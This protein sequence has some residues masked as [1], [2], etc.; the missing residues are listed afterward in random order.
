MKKDNRFIMTRLQLIKRLTG[1]PVIFTTTITV[2]L[3]YLMPRTTDLEFVNTLPFFAFLIL[4]VIL[5]FSFYKFLFIK[6]KKFANYFKASLTLYC[7]LITIVL[8]TEPNSIWE[9]LAVLINVLHFFVFCAY[10]MKSYSE[11]MKNISR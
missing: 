6:S 10:T 9:D 1:T 3:A 2:W 5:D 7:T 11:I 4:F 8:F